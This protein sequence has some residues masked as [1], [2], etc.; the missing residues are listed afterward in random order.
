MSENFKKKATLNSISAIIDL[1]SKSIYLIILNPIMI[2]KIGI[3]TFGIWNVIKQ[4]N[5]Y[6]NAVDSRSGEP[7]K[8][9][10][11]RD[12]NTVDESELAEYASGAIHI[13]VY[14]LPVLIL[15]GLLLS[16]YSPYILNVSIDNYLIVRL[17]TF[18]LVISLILNKSFSIFDSILRGMNLGYK[19]LGLKTLIIGVDLILTIIGLYLNFGLIGVACVQIFTAFLYNFVLY[20]VVVS[21]IAW[22]RYI[23]PSKEVISSLLGLSFQFLTWTLIYFI[24]GYS[25]LI[26]ISKILGHEEVSRYVITRYL[27]TTIGLLCI[28]IVG[29]IIPGIGVFFGNKD[30]QKILFIRSSGKLA[31]WYFLYITSSFVLL[32]NNYLVEI[33]IEKGMYL[34]HFENYLLILVSVF[35]IFMSMDNGLINVTLNIQSKIL[36]GFLSLIIMFSTYYF[37]IPAFALKGI[38]I[39]LILSRLFLYFGYSIIIYKSLNFPIKNVAN[40]AFQIIL[41]VLTS[42]IIYVIKKRTGFDYLNFSWQLIFFL[43][44]IVF[45]SIFYYWIILTSNHKH[46]VKKYLSNILIGLREK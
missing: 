5:Q 40:D 22:F 13:T 15:V 43:I 9:K 30:F 16:Y 45:F 31:V 3:G 4:L 17:T 34:G 29:G 41:F 14:F 39:G 32:F 7:L 23:K 42:Y 27:I 24:I 20:R 10:I 33:W 35:W 18:F 37:L 6:L 26:V 21:E 12:R 36:L 19:R 38:C 46:L 8:W 2:N 28:G 25:D 11:S 44:G 1:V